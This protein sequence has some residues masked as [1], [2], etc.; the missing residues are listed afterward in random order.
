MSLYVVPHPSHLYLGAA[1]AGARPRRA[2]V[3]RAAAV[4]PAR[5]TR[6]W[7]YLQVTRL[8]ILYAGFYF[9]F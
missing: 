1:R 6:L 7:G 8:F 9:Y 3:G 2:R 4:R 5:A